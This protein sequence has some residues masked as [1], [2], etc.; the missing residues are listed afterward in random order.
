MKINIQCETVRD[1][2]DYNGKYRGTTHNIPIRQGA[3]V[4]LGVSSK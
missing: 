2:S 3:D 4:F 1:D